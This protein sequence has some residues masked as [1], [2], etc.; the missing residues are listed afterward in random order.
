MGN[1]KAGEENVRKLTHI[2]RKSVGI[3]FPIEIV[4][5]M[6]WKKGQKVVVKRIKGGLMIKDF[7]SKK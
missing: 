5:E 7:Y 6:K 3:T 2:G 1:K 4:K